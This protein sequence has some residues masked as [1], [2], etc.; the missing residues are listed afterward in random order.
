MSEISNQDIDFTNMLI[1][2]SYELLEAL[3]S[4]VSSFGLCIITLP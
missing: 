1:N 3:E 4:H 2:R